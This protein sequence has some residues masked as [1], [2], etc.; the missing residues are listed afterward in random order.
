MPIDPKDRPI[1]VI[2]DD[3]TEEEFAAGLHIPNAD[4]PKNEKAR[5]GFGNREGKE[6]YGTDSED[7]ST[8]VSVNADADR[9]GHPADNMRTSDEGADQ[10]PNQD[11]PAPDDERD[12]ITGR[13]PRRGPVDELDADDLRPGPDEMEDPDS[14]V[15][16]GEMAP[17]PLRPITGTDTNAEQNDPGAQESGLDIGF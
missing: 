15:G 7:G 9:A 12:E 4:P 17:K 16:M 14:R 1:R 5:G 11:L 3:T 2:N 13:L 10:R 8:A 6:G